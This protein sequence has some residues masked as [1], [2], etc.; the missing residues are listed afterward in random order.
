M[1][2]MPFILQLIDLV[3]LGVKVIPSVALEYRI[4]R[5]KLDKIIAEN[6]DPTDEEWQD[7]L[8][9]IQKNTDRL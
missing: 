6:R 3:M 4:Q 9:A 5:Q 8:N 2:P 1:I 7:L